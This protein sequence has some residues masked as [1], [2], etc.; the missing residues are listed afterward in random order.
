M[1]SADNIAERLPEFY[2]AREKGSHIYQFI[3]AL[4]DIIDEQKREIIRIQDS[5]W[6]DSSSGVSLDLIASIFGLG[7]KRKEN[8]EDFRKRISNTAANLKKGGTIDAVRSQLAQYLAIS[9]QDVTIVEFPPTEMTLQKQVFSGDTW[10]MSAN[11][12]SSEALSIILAIS[13]GEAREPSIT[14]LDANLTV[15]FK[16]SLKKGDTLEISHGKATLNGVDS[17]SLIYFEGDKDIMAKNEELPKISRKPSKW[18]FREKITDTIARFDSSR[19]DENVF[20]E[21]VPPTTLTMKWTA[22]L[23]GSFEVRIPSEILDQNE[24]T[25]EERTQFVNA[26]KAAGIRS[27]VTIMQKAGEQARMEIVQPELQ[28]SR[29]SA[30]K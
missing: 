6:I 18:I 2:R 28:R 24:L 14:D 19:F 17:T 5:H 27:S 9:K 29:D 26:I 21:P 25:V 1:N 20:F 22:R 8:D 10:T 7:R 4:A 16:G 15:R 3:S 12:I 30:G 23:L 13:E 11:S